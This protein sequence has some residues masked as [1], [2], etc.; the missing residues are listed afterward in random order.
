MESL[1]FL[2]AP[3]LLTGYSTEYLKKGN[4]YIERAWFARKVFQAYAGITVICLLSIF[5][6]RNFPDSYIEG[7]GFTHF[8][9]ISEYVI[10][11]ILLCSLIALYAKKDR[12]EDHVFRLLAAAIIL[13][14][15][16][17]LSLRTY[18]GENGLLNLMGHYFK[19][20]SFY[21]IYKAIVE[22]GFDDPFSLLFRELKYREE[23][24]RQ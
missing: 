21:L 24:L 17:E 23:A 11:F 6:F 20:L 5:V 19:I 2:L 12:F 7:S 9:M 14:V 15:L 18:T 16:G 22:T 1:S 10:S 3:L 13:T 4:R 8:K